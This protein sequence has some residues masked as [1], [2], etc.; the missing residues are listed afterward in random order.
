MLTKTPVPAIVGEAKVLK[1][2]TADAGAWS[3]SGVELTYQWLRDGKKI[4]GAT[5][6]S[7]VLSEVDLGAQVGLVLERVDHLEERSEERVSLGA[8]ERVGSRREQR[9][10]AIERA[11]LTTAAPRERDQ[12]RARI[13]GVGVT[14]HEILALERRDGV[15]DGRLPH[16]E[17]LRHRRGAE[18]PARVEQ[19]EELGLERREPARL[20]LTLRAV[21]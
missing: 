18:G 21:S 9:A 13:D 3:P 12:L 11:P 1:N 8:P 14:P 2:L 4:K 15:R 5:A 19:R 16:R 17:E 7:Y 6:P 10:R 20:G